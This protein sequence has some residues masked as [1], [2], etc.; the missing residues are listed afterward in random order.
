MDY[1]KVYAEHSLAASPLP[2][3]EIKLMWGVI[4]VNPRSD[5]SELILSHWLLYPSRSQTFPAS[6]DMI[7]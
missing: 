6:T 2:L 7:A 5:Y 1:G 4:W 3:Q